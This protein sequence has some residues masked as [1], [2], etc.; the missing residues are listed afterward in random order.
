VRDAGEA[1]TVGASEARRL[2]ALIANRVRCDHVALRPITSFQREH[3]RAIYGFASYA[4][5]RNGG[6][7]NEC[8]PDERHAAMRGAASNLLGD[9][10]RPV[11]ITAIALVDLFVKF[12]QERR[13]FVGQRLREVVLRPQR[14]ADFRLNDAVIEGLSPR[15]GSA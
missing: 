5:K 8:T 10:G 7:P 15:V 4:R 2:W 14:A 9:Q 6:G 13:Q 11:A 1:A 12:R 3:Y